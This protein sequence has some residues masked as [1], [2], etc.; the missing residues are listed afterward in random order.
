M[1]VIPLKQIQKQIAEAASSQKVQLIAVSK[2][3]SIDQIKSLYQDGQRLFAENYVQE[4]LQ[5]IEQLKDLDTKL[6][7]VIFGQDEAIEA[8]VK[9]IKFARSG[10]ENKEKPWGSFLFAGPT[11]VGK[12]EVCK[13][14]AL[15][16]D[17]EVLFIILAYDYNSIYRQ[18]PER[19]RVSKAIFHVWNDNVPELLNE[20]K[21]PKRI[22]DAIE[23]YKSLQY[24][25]NIELVEMYNKK[26]DS[27][28]GILEEEKSASG[29]KNTMDSID[30]FRKAIQAIEREVVEE[31]ILEGELKGNISLSHFEKL[32]SNQKMYKAVTAKKV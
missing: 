4:S 2:N 28:L 22:K 9:S 32:K 10:L 1:E 14:L 6:K 17:K 3:Q 13:Q 26:I 11:G 19:Q 12:T 23:A 20:E 18:F 8:L 30:K 15:L 27:L 25:R 16:T 31:K 24:N 29:I 7:S 21:R 5:K